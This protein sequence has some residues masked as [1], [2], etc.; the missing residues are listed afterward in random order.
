MGNDI[1]Q[2]TCQSLRIE[3]DRFNM[4]FCLHFSAVKVTAV[5]FVVSPNANGWGNFCKCPWYTC[6]LGIFSKILPITMSHIRPH[7][8]DKRA[9]KLTGLYITLMLLMPFCSKAVDT[10]PNLIKLL[11]A[12]WEHKG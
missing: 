3:H 9:H 2:N 4:C 10:L 1:I 12:L 11:F 6:T 7:R 8:L 5:A